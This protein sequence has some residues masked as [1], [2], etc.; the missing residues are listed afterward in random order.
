MWTLE[1]YATVFQLTSC[2]EGKLRQK[3]NRID[4]L[5]ACFPGGSIT[6]APKVRSMEIIDELE[7]TRRSI[8]TGSI[9]YLGFGDTMDLNIV[10]RTIL[11]KNGQAF[12]QV[13]GAITYD[14]N[15]EAEYQETLD[16]AK[17][18]FQALRLSPELAVVT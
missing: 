1:K 4:L 16:K 13:G 15:P 8:Y 2:V 17:A 12:L 14:S 7:P 18:L 10:I 11:V 9:G 6:G 3:K 5:R